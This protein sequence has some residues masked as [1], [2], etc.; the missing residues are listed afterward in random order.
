MQKSES[1]LQCEQQ[2]SRAQG[3]R[4]TGRSRSRKLS[5]VEEVLGRR[6][7]EQEDQAQALAAE[8]AALLE[9]V[10]RSRR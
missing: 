1:E 8:A 7:W 4:C 6:W 10:R 2:A 5:P 9:S 3:A